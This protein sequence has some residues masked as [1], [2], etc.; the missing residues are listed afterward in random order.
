VAD[1]A[2]HRENLVELAARAAIREQLTEY[3]DAV[4]R[5]D[6]DRVKRTF[7][8][9]ATLDY[10]TSGVTAVDANVDLLRA[11]V[12]RLTAGSTL[13]GMQAV[14]EV[15]GKQ[16]RSDTTTFTAHTPAGGTEHRAR[17][18]IVVYADQWSCDPDGTWR[19]TDRVVHHRL[20]G[21]LDLE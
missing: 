6:W 9:S 5:H 15:Q 7:T 1:L 3:F 19:V 18:S 20:R 11:G 10:G 14:I 16:A 12:D 2:S 17:I 21:W 13:L 4:T 8:P